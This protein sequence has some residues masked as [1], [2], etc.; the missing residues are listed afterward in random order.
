MTIS[1]L[2]KL[3]ISMLTKLT[4][5]I[6]TKLTNME[7]FECIRENGVYKILWDFEVKT[8]HSISGRRSLI[9]EEKKKEKWICD[10]INFA[11]LVDGNVEEARTVGIYLELV[12]SLENLQNVKMTVMPVLVGGIAMCL[13]NNSKDPNG[14]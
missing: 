2:S 3:T 7:K 5:N 8:D 9:N 14:F 1:M 10:L 4:N 13:Q 12:K 11:V 6:L